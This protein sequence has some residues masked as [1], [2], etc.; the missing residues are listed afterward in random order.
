MSE[1]PRFGNKPKNKRT[2]NETNSMKSDITTNWVCP[3][4]YMELV[5]DISRFYI[6]G[7][8]FFLLQMLGKTKIQ[9]GESGACTSNFQPRWM[10][11]F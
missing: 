7:N 6:D 9:N 2:N 11:L 3:E 8:I 1:M 4:I 10:C 5:L